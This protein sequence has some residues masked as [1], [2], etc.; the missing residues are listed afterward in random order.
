MRFLTFS[1][2]WLG[3]C[4]WI[5]GVQ[6]ASDKQP[7]YKRMRCEPFNTPTILH[8]MFSIRLLGAMCLMTILKKSSF[9]LMSASFKSIS[10]TDSTKTKMIV[11]TF[12]RSMERVPSLIIEST[13]QHRKLSP[14]VHSFL[15]RYAVPAQQMIAIGQGAL[16][17]RGTN[18]MVSKT[19]RRRV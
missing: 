1:N 19:P 12:V 16:Q 7:C 3:T 14:Q 2:S 17:R 4:L 15:G 10:K 11:G 5:T 8:S 6:A 18:L 9:V 13:H